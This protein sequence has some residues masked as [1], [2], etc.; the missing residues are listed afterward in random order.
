MKNNFLS[1]VIQKPCH[2]TCCT[3]IYQLLKTSLNHSDS[4]SPDTVIIAPNSCDQN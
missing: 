1:R 3:D 2:W 4:R